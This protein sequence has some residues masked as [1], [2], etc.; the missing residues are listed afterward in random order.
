MTSVPP[1]LQT[2]MTS[3]T[4]TRGQKKN[5]R[6]RA[7]REAC[8]VH[9]EAPEILPTSGEE[10]QGSDDGRVPLQTQQQPGRETSLDPQLP[11]SDAESEPAQS[12]ASAQLLISP[13]PDVSPETMPSGK[14][15]GSVLLQTPP[16]VPDSL[17]ESVVS[18]DVSTRYTQEEAPSHDIA[19]PHQTKDVPRNSQ[20]R[21]PKKTRGKIRT[22]WKPCCTDAQCNSQGIEMSTPAPPCILSP[23]WKSR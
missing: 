6:R 7:E 8:A 9:P 4:I 18:Q 19:V 17:L 13:A 3:T 11:S 12:V 1:P 20:T 14:G 15:K 10:N 2:Q 21:K 16:A 23:R 5:L 22:P